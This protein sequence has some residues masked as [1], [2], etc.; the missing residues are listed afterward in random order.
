MSSKV[1]TDLREQTAADTEMRLLNDVILRGWPESKEEVQ[2][3]LRKYWGFRDELAAYDGLIFKSNQ[4]IIPKSL[5]KKMLE[6]VHKGHPGVQSGIKR[7][8][9]VLFWVNMTRDIQNMIECCSVCQQYQR[10]NQKSIVVTKEIPDLPFERVASDLF[11]FRGNEYILIVD[12]WSNFYDFKK[13]SRSTSDEVINIMKNWFAVHGIPRVLE[14]DN[15]PQYSSQDFRKFADEWGFDHKT[16]SPHFPRSNGLAERFVQVAK[17][18]LKRCHQDGSDVNLALLLSRNT[19]R[20]DNIPSPNERLLGR[21]TRSTLPVTTKILQPKVVEGVK[22]ALCK[23][24]QLQK[25]YA[26]RGAR[27]P[28]E[29]EPGDKVMVQNT[30]SKQWFPGEVMSKCEFDRSY[31][32][33]DGERILRRNTQYVR[34]K[35][36]NFPDDND[37]GPGALIPSRVVEADSESQES[38]VEDGT[39][40]MNLDTAADLVPDEEE[41]SQRRTTRSG[42]VV[43]LNKKPEFEYY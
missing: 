17:N 21:L 9:Q 13:L 23:E 14:T 8:K 32:V 16:S 20:N 12:S 35:K 2:P 22:D 10:S 18:L 42:R 19:P 38:N 15:G 28:A 7:A 31:L 25:Q 6:A 27:N 33:S 34:K 29:L 39:T 26:D 43:K 40:E 1:S 30:T 36:M 4:I 11:H 37:Q 3:D 5:R 41:S 24:R